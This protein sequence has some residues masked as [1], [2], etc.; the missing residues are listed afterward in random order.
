MKY[1]SRIDGI[2]TGGNDG[3]GVYYRA[4]QM[5]AAGEPVTM[6]SIGDH[7][8]KTDTMILDAMKASMDAG[9]LGY[10]P[11]SGSEGL[12]EA[13]AERI[14]A[15]TATPAHKDNIVVTPG[16]QSALYSAM[17][18]TLDPGQSC[19]LLDPF[20]A[21]YEQTIRAASAEPLPVVCSAD[22]GF[23][24][25]LA[26]IAATIRPDTGAILIN[27]PNNPSGAVYRRERLEGLAALCRYHGIWLISDEVY[28]TQVW[29]TEFISARDLPGMADH[30]I[31][32]NSLSKSHAMTG[33]RI[34]W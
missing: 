5:K 31:V 20:Y 25:D 22:D 34:G 7:D 19:I 6:L 15:R 16:G 18:A 24:P 11:V 33:S 29:Q 21:T 17:L 26:G 30:V 13:I 9:N 3:W 10:A 2:V 8:I 28:D 23:Q 27:T 12:R 32:V 1:S 14:T 4:R